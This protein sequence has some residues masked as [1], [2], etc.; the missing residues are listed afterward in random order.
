[1]G[2]VGNGKSTIIDAFIFVLYGHA[3]R[4]VNKPI[5]INSITNKNCLVELDFSI[6]NNEYMVRRGMK[7][8]VFEIYKNGKMYDQ[9]ADQ[10]SYQDLL[11]NA[12][13]GLNYKTCTQ[14]I[15]LGKANYTPFM[16][17]KAADRRVV[18]ENLIDIAI[19]S[20]MNSQLKEKVLTNKQLISELEKNIMLKT[21]AIDL[22]KKHVETMQNYNESLV[23]EKQKKIEKLRSE[24]K[25][26]FS[27]IEELQDTIKQL[28][29]STV[30]VSSHKEKLNKFIELE[31]KLSNKAST[32][33]SEVKFLHDNDTCPTCKQDIDVGFRENTKV[34][35]SD[36][37]K[38]Y[39]DTIE[40][41]KV[42]KI[43][44]NEVISL[45]DVHRST[46]STKNAELSVLNGNHSYNINQINGL[47]NEIVKLREYKETAPSIDVENTKIELKELEN[48]REEAYLDKAMMETAGILL[49]DTGIKA[50]VIKQYIPIM[51]KQIAKY[52]Q[53]L[54]SQV[55]FELDENFN[56]VIRSAF[57]DEF[58]YYSFSEGEKLKIDIALVLTWRDIA[59]SRN[60]AS[61]NLFIID[62]I[63]DGSS[64]VEMQDMLFDVLANPNV[65]LLRISHVKGIYDRFDRVLEFEK[66]KNFSSVKEVKDPVS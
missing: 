22:A 9:N 61:S 33:M 20:V 16:S 51:N 44:L 53:Q 50:K 49:K 19:F 13:L 32:L 58:S 23:E 41:I 48:Q 57:G 1:V 28:K 2:K 43:A 47:E 36:K 65:N 55:V 60:S 66:V 27:Q 38:E 37:H 29:E 11:E 25:E 4:D 10:K 46:I 31:A 45:A 6:G 14:V 21:Q 35:K 3:F 12:I 54:D 42:E 34:E 39:V 26:I 52:L 64:D 59:K 56:D 5:L 7:P 62:E 30:D 18:V 8:T 63:F 17:L 40:K 15:V 24:N